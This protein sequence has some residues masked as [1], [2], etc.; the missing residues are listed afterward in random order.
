MIYQIGVTDEIT[1]C[2]CCGKENLKRTVVFKT[3]ED[4]LF[5]GSDCATRFAKENKTK[6]TR[7]TKVNKKG[8]DQA[9]VQIEEE[10][11]VVRVEFAR[12][13]VKK[14][15]T[16]QEAWN[17]IRKLEHDGGFLRLKKMYEIDLMDI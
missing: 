17:I 12:L 4:Y 10:R 15:K 14:G 8:Q 2:D 1:T 5:F 3:E 6:I 9:A 11:A 7:K 13:L 16:L